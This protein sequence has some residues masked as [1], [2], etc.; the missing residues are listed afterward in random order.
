MVHPVMARSTH[1]ACPQQMKITQARVTCG[2]QRC[3]CCRRRHTLDQRCAG[4]ITQSHSSYLSGCIRSNV[5]VT[6]FIEK[7]FY[8]YPPNTLNWS[9]LIGEW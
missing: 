6:S 2:K 7:G 5:T 9:Y 4:A 3:D 8:A 1:I